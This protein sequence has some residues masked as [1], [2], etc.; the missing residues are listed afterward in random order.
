M[1]NVFRRGIL[2]G[3][4][5]SAVGTVFV[6]VLIFVL[7][8][9]YTTAANTEKYISKHLEELLDT[10]ESTAGV[11]CFVEDKQLASELIA[12][13]L[14][15]NGIAGVVV[16]A[17]NKELARANRSGKAESG[18]EMAG[19]NIIRK[20]NSPFNKEEVIGEII[21]YRDQ[22]AIDRQ[23]SEEVR[24]TISMLVIQ[25]VLVA[26]AVVFI[27][28][29]IVVRPIRELSV[30]LRRID[31]AAG[32]KLQ[33]PEG[34]EG[35]EIS[36]LADDINKLTETLVSALSNEKQLRAK[37]EIDEK[38]FRSIFENAGSGIFIA[39]E[40]GRLISFNRSFIRLTNFPI[41]EY[42]DSPKLSH[43]S[44]QDESPLEEAIAA[45]IK[46]RSDQT[47][48][49]KLNGPH[50]VWLNIV[51]TAIAEDQ[52]QGVI[53]DVT[54]GKQS[55]AA[56]LHMA[57]TD[58]LTGFANRAGLESYFPELIR[59][60]H[61]ESLVM[62]IV[63][64]KG[65]KQINESMGLAAGD[66]LLKI[67]A[68]RLMSSL[69]KTDWFA[70]LGGDEFVVILQGG[71]G[72]PAAESVAL[73]IVERLSKVAEIGDTKV[74]S[75]CSI[76]IACYPSDGH[77]LHALLR[78]AEFALNFAKT[79]GKGDVQAFAPEMVVVA[80]QRRKLESELALA[81]QR[82]ELR[83]FYQPI[84]D[85]NEGRIVGAEALVR[86]QHSERGLIPPDMF[87]PLAEES[88]LIC[89]I[90]LWVL[91]TACRQLATWQSKGEQLYLS[92]NVSARQIPDALP[93]SLIR[94]TVQRFGVPSSSL[95]LE[96]TEGVLLTDIDKGINWIKSLR[97]EGFRIYMDDFG[98]GYSSLSYLKRFPI[99]VVKID[100]S[101]IRDMREDT[102]DR[103]LVQAITAMS[104][105]LNLQVVAEGVE[106]EVQI[107]LL[108]EMGCQYGQGY[109]FSKPV[110]VDD[111]DQLRKTGLI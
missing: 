67:T 31:P 91:E 28:Y 75:G 74:N 40:V 33:L 37:Q 89:D 1:I 87:I 64:I 38:K 19:S 111:F 82:E 32:E 41:V 107:S 97:E 61:G 62:M 109:Y 27:L 68:T 44:W 100:R 6:I 5:V 106:N 105:A 2:F 58:K 103:V 60:R 77:D 98:T 9:A 110:P 92:V 10:V 55:E 66:E 69:K 46:T 70:R 51:M 21:V 88:D 65:F 18:M 35:N 57:V 84:V 81:I 45:C 20:I 50:P 53:T 104:H 86:W 36:G 90:G 23:V 48:E 4:I 12:G 11:A 102:S 22:Q 52:V 15:N 13:L 99:N 34:H 26:A 83:L 108:K 79:A 94:E 29:F 47:I 59:Q 56:A 17:A 39:D 72:R 14:K 63:D 93:A 42:G 25:L 43:I 73:R 7:V 85:L 8:T 3:T 95:V 54:Q 49:H 30:S 24:M 76:G 16:T 80:E 96:I 71:A 101:F 78:S